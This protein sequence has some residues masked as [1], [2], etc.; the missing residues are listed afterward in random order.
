LH[1]VGTGEW[2]NI[3]PAQVVVERWQLTQS[4]VPFNAWLKPF[5]GM[6]GRLLS[7]QPAQAVG[8]GL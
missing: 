4:P 3:P 2:E 5:T 1:E 8:I 7:W 6:A